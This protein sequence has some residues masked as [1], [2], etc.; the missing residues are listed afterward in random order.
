MN[1]LKDYTFNN[2]IMKIPM[3]P[4]LQHI[5]D[6]DLSFFFYDHGYPG[7]F[8]CI[9]TNPIRP[10]SEQQDKTFSTTKGAQTRNH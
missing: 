1:R 8:T 10:W 9:L 6:H 5:D 4:V 3:T 2:T 7:Q